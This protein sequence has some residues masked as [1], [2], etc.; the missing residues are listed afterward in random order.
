MVRHWLG[1]GPAAVL[2][3]SVPPVEHE[4]DKDSRRDA[5]TAGLPRQPLAISRRGLT[6]MILEP[7]RPCR[8]LLAL[9]ALERPDLFNVYELMGEMEAA[10]RRAAAERICLLGSGG[11]A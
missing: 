10:M 3:Q 1:K 4:P 9:R 11:K 2:P 6:V 8:W 7:P 5:R